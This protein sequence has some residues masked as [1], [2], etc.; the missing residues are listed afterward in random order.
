MSVY[1][2]IVFNFMFGLK[3]IL[4]LFDLIIKDNLRL[5]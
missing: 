1:L 2:Y 5:V 3:T 4:V